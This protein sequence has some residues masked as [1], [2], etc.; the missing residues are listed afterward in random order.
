MLGRNTTPAASRAALASR[1]RGRVPTAVPLCLDPL[2]ARL[3]EQTGFAAGYVSGG[4]LGY[5][6]A[7]SEALLTIT[8]LATLTASISRR[9]D[10]PIIVDGAVGFG[11]PVHVTRMTWDFEAAGAAGVEIEDQVSPKRV[12]H[13]RGVEHLVPTEQMVAKVRFCVAARQDSNFLVIVRTGSVRHEGVDSAIE[14]AKAY[15]AAG[16]DCIMLSPTGDAAG[17]ARIRDAVSIPLATI[18]Y[19]DARSMDDWAALGVTLVI[20]P[21]TPHV[22]AYRATRDLFART[23]AGQPSG[24]ERAESAAL[25]HELS[26]TAGLEELYEI[27]RQTTEP[28][29]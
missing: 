21:M 24:I 28:G 6:L 15:E 22:A 20:D 18:S 2:T 4:A 10:L 27:E 23:L 3:A 29:T 16:A 12:S 17:L 14:R 13:H 25:Y 11:D 5:S 19:F 8:E 26:L 7:I 9:S 1:I